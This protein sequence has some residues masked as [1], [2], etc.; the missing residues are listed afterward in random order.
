MWLHRAHS[1]HI[2]VSA[3]TVATALLQSAWRT[4]GHRD[5]VAVPIGSPSKSGL[6]SQYREDLRGAC[7][8]GDRVN[9]LRGAHGIGNRHFCLFGERRYHAPLCSGLESSVDWSRSPSPPA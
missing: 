7:V 5:A 3:A 8:V 1:L 4:R 2:D 9:L 6:F